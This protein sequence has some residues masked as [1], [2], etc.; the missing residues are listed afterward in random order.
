MIWCVY[1]NTNAIIIQYT[2]SV[3]RHYCLL[4]LLYFASWFDLFKTLK[5][6]FQNSNVRMWIDDLFKWKS[7]VKFLW[8]P[9]NQPVCSFILNL[10]L[11]ICLNNVFVLLANPTPSVPECPAGLSSHTDPFGCAFTH[12][13]INIDDSCPNIPKDQRDCR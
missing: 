7:K 5:Q 10:N 11:G 6:L 12:V 13:F 8:I 4:L 2:S 9:F 1:Y 3:K